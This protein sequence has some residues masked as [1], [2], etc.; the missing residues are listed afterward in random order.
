MNLPVDW[1]D[2]TFTLRSH[3]GRGNAGE[4]L[5]WSELLELFVPY[6]QATHY[7]EPYVTQVVLGQILSPAP[8]GCF[9]HLD[10]FP[11]PTR[12]TVEA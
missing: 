7:A 5:F 2:R 11:H 8:I 1:P 3:R 9:W 12:V 4:R 10:V 6:D